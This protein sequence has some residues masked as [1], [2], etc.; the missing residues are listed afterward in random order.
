MSLP[1]D[2]QKYRQIQVAFHPRVPADIVERWLSRVI[3]NNYHLLGEQGAEAYLARFGRTIGEE[4]AVYLAIKAEIEGYQDMANGFWKKAHS[5]KTDGSKSKKKKSSSIATKKRRLMV[6][7]E[8]Q[9]HFGLLT[10]PH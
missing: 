7:E 2:I 4:K 3:P 1:Q 8:Q 6:L 10:P 5:L 9:A